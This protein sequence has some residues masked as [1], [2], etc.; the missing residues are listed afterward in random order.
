MSFQINFRSEGEGEILPLSFVLFC[1]RI[2]H[3]KYDLLYILCRPHPNFAHTDQRALAQNI[4]GPV[5]KYRSNIP[6]RYKSFFTP[7]MKL[8]TKIKYI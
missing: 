7:K 1:I 8:V 2:F 6:H 3:M 4:K 5:P